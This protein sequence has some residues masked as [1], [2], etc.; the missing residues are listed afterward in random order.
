[1]GIHLSHSEPAAHAPRTAE[2]AFFLSEAE[3]ERLT[4]Y[5]RPHEQ[6]AELH[7]RG[8]HRAHR[9]RLGRVALTRAHYDAVER[10]EVSRP[11]PQL[12][13]LRKP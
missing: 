1:M 7:R 2:T 9:D 5:R 13:R 11:K 4:G 8:F 12:R 6:L 3:I 10:G